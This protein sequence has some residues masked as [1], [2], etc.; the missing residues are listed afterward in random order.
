MSDLLKEVVEVSVV[1]LEG[2]IQPKSLVVLRKTV[3]VLK[4]TY[5]STQGNKVTVLTEIKLPCNSVAY[6]P[7]RL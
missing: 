6:K 4:E 1:P 3:K 2:Q 7:D 5:I